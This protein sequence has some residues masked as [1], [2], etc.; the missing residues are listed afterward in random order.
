MDRTTSAQG[1]EGTNGTTKDRAGRD[2]AAGRT[3]GPAYGG[4]YIDRGEHAEDF[5]P[6][7]LLNNG[8]WI[9]S[10]LTALD[11]E[12]DDTDLGFIYVT[13]PAG[14]SEY[15]PMGRFD[16]LP[17]NPRYYA[18]GT[19]RRPTFTFLPGD[20]FAGEDTPAGPPIPAPVNPNRRLAEVRVLPN[21]RMVR[22]GSHLDPLSPTY[23][24]PAA[25]PAPA[26]RTAGAP[27]PP[28]PA[29]PR[30][31][32]VAVATNG[33]PAALPAPAPSP[34]PAPLALPAPRGDVPVTVTLAEVSGALGT[35]P[36]TEEQAERLA[37]EAERAAEGTF[38]GAAASGAGIVPPPAPLYRRRI[39]KGRVRYSPADGTEGADTPLYTPE[40]EGRA[41]RFHPAN[42]AARALAAD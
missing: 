28:P 37:G 23:A 18:R 7:K 30:V 41:R 15:R 12:G 34:R 42:E 1:I 40:G 29:G 11:A 36:V 25:L 33:T 24:P 14:G 3:W 9:A 19:G 21:G 27:I 20:G 31:R 22:A 6:T 2:R 13:T 16:R 5:A 10:A 32:V 8:A 35:A 4:G 26:P 38:Q 39:I 17:L